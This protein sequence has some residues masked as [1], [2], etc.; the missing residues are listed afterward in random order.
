[1][2]ARFSQPQVPAKLEENIVRRD[3]N[4]QTT[5]H[6]L[7]ISGNQLV[8]DGQ[9]WKCSCGQWESPVPVVG[10]YGHTTAKA[11]ITQVNM[12]FGKHV[13]FAERKA[14]A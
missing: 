9:V 4:N 1:M 2:V 3:E 11:R 13:K 5:D 7:V 12:A 10:S 14:K 6:K 8:L